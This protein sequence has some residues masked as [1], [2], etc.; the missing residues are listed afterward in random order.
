MGGSKGGLANLS[1]LRMLRLMKML[2]LLRMIRLMRMFRE[3]RL[4][5]SSLFACVTSMLWT[6][7]LILA[8]TYLFGVAV[9]QGCIGY[10]Q[11]NPD[12]IDPTIRDDIQKYWG[13]V[14][15][16]ILSLY[17]ASLGGQDWEVIIAPLEHVGA[18]YYCLFL[19]YI[20]VFAFV[21]MNVISSIF[22]ESILKN[23][24]SDQQFIIEKHM[25]QKQVYIQKLQQLFQLMDNE[26]SGEISYEVFC[27]HSESPHMLS[28]AA[29]LE[30]DIADASKFFLEISDRGRRSV[31]MET[32]VVGCIKL[33]GAAKSVDLL[34]INYTQKKA[35]AFAKKSS[36]DLHGMVADQHETCKGLH[37][38]ALEQNWMSREVHKIVRDLHNLDTLVKF[39]HK[40]IV[41][42]HKMIHDLDTLVKYD[43][44]QI[45]EREM[46]QG[47]TATIPNEAARARLRMQL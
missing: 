44:K 14:A 46:A 33:K 37:K 2:K 28:F 21:I 30:I 6:T 42:E 20:A 23:A 1:F 43:H 19:V 24:D 16:S 41:E 29:S 35:N 27:A 25:E 10:L 36:T 5:M 12:G 45:G 9:V 40:Q 22:L 13:S 34:D 7:M 18:V 39:D 8:V 17:M 11:L 26:K 15:T 31:D 32:F 47:L 3:L 4:I 38:M